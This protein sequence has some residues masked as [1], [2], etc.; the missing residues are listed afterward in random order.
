MLMNLWNLFGCGMLFDF[1]V[2]QGGSWD[3]V[4]FVGLEVDVVLWCLCVVGLWVCELEWWVF[5]GEFYV[6]GCSVSGNSLLLMVDGEIFCELFV[7]CLLVVVCVLL[8]G[9][10]MQVEWLECYD[11][12]YYLCEEYSMMGYLEWCLLVWCLCFDDFWYIWVYLDFYSGVVVGVFD[13]GWC[14]SCWLFF[15]LYSWDWLLL[16]IWCLLWDLW[17]FGFSFGGLVVCVSGC[18]IGWCCLCGCCLKCC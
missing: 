12:Y 9:V 16:L 3:W 15:L 5:D 14:G 11:F 18:W 1:V 10:L 4:L 6:F 13:D 7:D 8:L 2:Y 17:M